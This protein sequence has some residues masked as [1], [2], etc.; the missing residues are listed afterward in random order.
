M[1][2]AKSDSKKYLHVSLTSNALSPFS[3]IPGSVKK[4]KKASPR[5]IIKTRITS[6]ILA[7]KRTQAFAR[8]YRAR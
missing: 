6:I 2:P 3:I 8:A 1:I 4:I 7:T 5:I